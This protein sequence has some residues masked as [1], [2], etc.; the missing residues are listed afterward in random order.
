M[1]GRVSVQTDGAPSAIGPYSQAIRGGPLIFCAGQ[2]GTDPRTG[3]LADGVAAQADRAL[4]NL[5][6]VLAAAGSGLDRVVKTIIFL[7]DM[8]DFTTVNEVYARHLA[9]PYPARSTIA[10]RALPKGALVEIEAVALAGDAS[11]ESEPS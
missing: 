6:A 2:V 8:D 4:T 11:G 1:T 5:A 9:A 3:T 7:V 10:V